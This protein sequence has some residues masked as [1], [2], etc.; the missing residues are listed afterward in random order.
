[1]KPSKKSN[2][3]GP[4]EK[5]KKSRVDYNDPE[6]FLK[7]DFSNIEYQKSKSSSYLSRKKKEK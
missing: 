5:S 4:S 7:G 2:G 1:M 6:A 3:Q